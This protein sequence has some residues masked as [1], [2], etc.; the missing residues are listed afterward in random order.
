MISLGFK[1]YVAIFLNR[2]MKYLR[3]SYTGLLHH[4]DSKTIDGP[5]S[6]KE[7]YISRKWV[8]GSRIGVHLDRWNGTMEFYLDGFPLGVAFKGNFYKR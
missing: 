7:N 4:N 2:N 6:L 3:Y 5:E 1:L 8:P